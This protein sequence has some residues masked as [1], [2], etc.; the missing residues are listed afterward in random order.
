M[1]AS[2]AQRDGTQRAPIQHMSTT[3]IIIL[4]ILAFLVFG[5]GGLWYRGRN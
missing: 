1:G 3:T 5:G 4:V 2:C